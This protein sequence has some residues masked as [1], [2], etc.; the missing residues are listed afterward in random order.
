MSQLLLKPG[1]HGVDVVPSFFAAASI[2]LAAGCG[3]NTSTGGPNTAG[4][5]TGKIYVAVYGADAIDIFDSTSHAMTGT[6]PLGSGRGPA[7]L[8]KTPDGKKLFTANWKDNSL[9]IID[10]ASL[11]ATNLPLGSRPWVIAMAPAGDVLYAGLN[12]GSI[13]V[14]STSTGVITRSIDTQMQLPESL[15][16][17]SDGNTLYAVLVDASDVLNFLSG[18]VTGLSASTGAV[19]NPAVTVGEVPAWITVS[20]DG[21]TL[22]TLNF[23]GDSISVVDT[24]SWAVRGTITLASGA[25]P[26]VGGVSSSGELVVTD[27]G[28][29]D[30]ALVRQGE[31]SVTSTFKTNGRPVGVDFSPD[32]KT[33]Y[34]T[35][36]G[37]SSLMTS[38]SVTAL[39]SGDLDS[40]IGTGPSE[41]VVF[42]VASGAVTGDPIVVQ[43]AGAIS[44]VVE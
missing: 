32:G 36:F 21:T 14:V 20:P 26:I 16:V 39:Q 30:V 19:V 28:T 38:P 12:A 24:A 15:A 35:D 6:I 22:Y 25:W 8:L 3:G 7:I 44:V 42:D 23:L 27:F 37:P 9:S 5:I 31:A 17:S 34:V 11:T 29:S 4:D 40:E 1:V 10:P 33:G 13:A 43:G 41:V 18:S 2:A